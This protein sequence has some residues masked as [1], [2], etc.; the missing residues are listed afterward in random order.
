MVQNNEMEYIRMKNNAMEKLLN[1]AK[2]E[3]IMGGTSADEN[4]VVNADAELVQIDNEVE[5][6]E[7]VETPKQEVE[8]TIEASAVLAKLNAIG[9]LPTI[10]KLVNA[11][12]LT[13]TSI[14]EAAV[15]IHML[16]DH[17]NKEQAVVVNSF[18]NQ[19]ID[20]MNYVTSK[21]TPEQM[22]FIGT[23]LASGETVNSIL[24]AD[25]SVAQMAELQLA[26]VEKHI[27][28][29][30]YADVKLK[31]SQLQALRKACELGVDVSVFKD[32]AVNMTWEQIDLLASLAYEGIDI[33]DVLKDATADDLTVESL[34]TVLM[35][36]KNVT[37]A[38]N[39]K[40]AA[41]GK[42]WQKVETTVEKSAKKAEIKTK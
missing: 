42:H 12:N 6:V 29:T 14:E 5:T 37:D 4:T 13:E 18:D 28:V 21:Y 40:L 36:Q 16:T 25:Y 26:T 27:D 2:N 39:P 31:P 38:Q 3:Y 24:N 32:K 15:A 22:F 33:T 7:T 9:L 10:K 30:K 23:K 34:R 17:L 11:E 41:D 19:G 35:E 1:Q 20:L 8:G